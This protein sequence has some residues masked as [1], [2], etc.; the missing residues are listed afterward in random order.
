MNLGLL[1]MSLLGELGC[2]PKEDP[3][4]WTFV[5]CVWSAQECAYSCNQS[6]AVKTV[7]DPAVCP[8]EGLPLACY[9]GH[10][11]DS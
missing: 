10:K 11:A 5:S 4:E 9:C 6:D 2:E 7:D 3:Y 1:Y 8:D